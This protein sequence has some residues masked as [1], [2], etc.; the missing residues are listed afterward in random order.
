MELGETKWT[1]G[2]KIELFGKL[3]AGRVCCLV[4]SAGVMNATRKAFQAKQDFGSLVLA[5]RQ[6]I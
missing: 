2:Q 6:L 4:I 5:K 1:G 3:E